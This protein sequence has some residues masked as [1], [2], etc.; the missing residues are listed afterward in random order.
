[1]GDFYNLD[2]LLKKKD[3]NN[4]TP[5]TFIITN[6]RTSG[7]TTAVLTYLLL[8]FDEN[9][10]QFVLLYRTQSEIDSA[11][12][13][14]TEINNRLNFGAFT[15]KPAVKRYI[16]TI[17]LN[18]TPI[19]YAVTL[20]NPD[21]IKKY[22]P[23][24]SSVENIFFDEYQLESKRYLKDEY[25]KYI[26]VITSIARGGGE[27]IRD[28]IKIFLAGNPVDLFNPYYI[29]YKIYNRL[30]PDTKYLRGNGFVGDFRLDTN[31]STAYEASTLLQSLGMSDS[32][33]YYQYL[34]Q[35]KY[36][37]GTN[38]LIAKPSG[39]TR[40]LFTLQHDNKKHGIRLST[41]NRCIYCTKSYDPSSPYLF[42]LKSDDVDS[43]T[44]MLRT[45]TI[46]MHYLRSAFTTGRLYFENGEIKTIVVDLLALDRSLK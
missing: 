23:I 21:T 32:D 43:N 19:G 6:N 38:N 36:L 13:I 30:L 9:S 1:M 29:K 25:T 34:T 22:S 46:E 4:R 18:D 5:N 26:S 41:Q 20:S 7:K 28:S 45:N 2:K 33:S 12:E 37:N 14:F 16:N 10:H 40:Y 39:N 44:F 8:D 35:I 24:F 27:R 15:L 17:Y 42:V 11:N 3:I 31:A